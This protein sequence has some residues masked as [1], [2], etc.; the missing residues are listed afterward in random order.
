MNDELGK[1]EI[2]ALTLVG[3]AA[4]QWDALLTGVLASGKKD[5]LIM[6]GR[7]LQAWRNGEFILQL[8]GEIEDLIAKGRLKPEQLCT[9]GAKAGLQELMAALEDPPVDR[10]KFE[11]LKAVFLKS[12]QSDEADTGVP[13]TQSIIRTIARLD[14][15]EIT[16]LG[17]IYRVARAGKHRKLELAGVAH[18]WEK[19][20]VEEGDFKYHELVRNLEDSLV[21]YRLLSPRIHSDDSGVSEGEHFRLT[22]FGLKVCEF[23]TIEEA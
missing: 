6:P 12:L 11:A 15:V 16:L 4:K 23:L 13:V 5:F 8:Q 3:A 2:S 18:A 1:T 10:V 22:P 14:S 19:V 20:L 7:L 21:R 17:A 9:E